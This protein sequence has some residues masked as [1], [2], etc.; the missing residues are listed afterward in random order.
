SPSPSPLGSPSPSPLG[1][2][3]PSPLGSPSP[4]PLGSPSPSP[5]SDVSTARSSL[6]SDWHAVTR[7]KERMNEEAR[8][9][10][11]A[12]GLRVKHSCRYIIVSPTHRR[13]AQTTF[14]VVDADGAPRVV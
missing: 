2:P 11:P 3:S 12:T 10:R 4:S 1:S 13:I 5:D 7:L 6:S 8:F 14:F 9:M